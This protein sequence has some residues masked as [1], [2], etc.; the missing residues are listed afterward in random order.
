MHT[1][2]KQ[3]LGS[4]NEGWRA[5]KMATPPSH[6]AKSPR[7]LYVT[8]IDV[9]TYFHVVI[10]NQYWLEWWALV[11]SPPCLFIILLFYLHIN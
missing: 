7:E 5:Q 10:W 8:S 11:D 2:H 6:Q 9:C 3:G 4:A 1:W